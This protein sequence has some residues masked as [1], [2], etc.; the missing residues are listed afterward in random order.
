MT[1]LVPVRVAVLVTTLLDFSSA[2]HA[3]ANEEL[4]REARTPCVPFARDDARRP[5]ILVTGG[6]GFVGGHLLR[7]LLSEF[8][9]SRFKVVDSLWRG[10]IANLLDDDGVALLDLRH[11]VCVEDL[12]DAASA[13][14][15][16]AHADLV[17]HLADIVAGVDFVF[18]HQW[19]VWEQNV[20]INTNVVRAAVHHGVKDFVYV[21]TACSFPLELQMDC[22]RAPVSLTLCVDICMKLLACVCV[23]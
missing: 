2:R 21:G 19:F 9:G 18:S 7:R 14:R 8:S 3:T 13:M 17:F 23:A 1:R 10:T 22:A 15:T 6:A 20:R 11:D 12:T 4:V 16:L 5:R